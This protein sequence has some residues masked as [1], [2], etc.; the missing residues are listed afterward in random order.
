MEMGITYIKIRNF[1]SI[2]KM[3]YNLSRGKVNCM[4][5]KNEVGKTTI[6]RA[7]T[8]F[9]ELVSDFFDKKS[10][11][12]KDQYWVMFWFLKFVRTKGT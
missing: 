3:D 6:D 12:A 4:L 9:Y 7:I 5:G 11:C 1:R 10:I 8:Y 2:K